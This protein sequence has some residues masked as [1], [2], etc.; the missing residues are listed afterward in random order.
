MGWFFTIRFSL[1]LVGAI[2]GCD[3]GRCW[4]PL[5]VSH[6]AD[7]TW[8]L[9]WRCLVT[10]E[11]WTDRWLENCHSTKI[12]QQ[13]TSSILTLH[14]TIS[15]LFPM[16]EDSLDAPLM[17]DGLDLHW[18]KRGRQVKREWKMVVVVRWTDIKVGL[19]KER[20]GPWLTYHP[21]FSI[22]ALI[23]DGR[24]WLLIAASNKL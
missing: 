2:L 10:K 3:K 7:K 24:C 22:Q 18:D 13:L 21:D 17:L 14:S 12:S 23:V 1:K 6:Y 4:R 8:M 20:L 16:M 15:I 9:L 19:F 11:T 5:K